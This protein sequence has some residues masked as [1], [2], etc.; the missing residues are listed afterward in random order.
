M[1]KWSNIDDLHYLDTCTV[2]STDSRLT[3]VTGTLNVC[4]NLAKTEV[5]SNL[6]AILS[7]KDQK[8][9]VPAQ[10]ASWQAVPKP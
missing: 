10:K 6:S 8:I 3:T 5:V 7:L 9:P 1:W 4:L 2:D